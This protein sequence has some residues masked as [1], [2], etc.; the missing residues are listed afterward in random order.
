M[1]LCIVY[2]VRACVRACICVHIYIH[3]FLACITLV[4]VSFNMR[5]FMEIWFDVT[6]IFVVVVVIVARII[7]TLSIA[8]L[9][10]A[11]IIPAPQIWICINLYNLELLYCIFSYDPCVQCSNVTRF[12]GIRIFSVCFYL[13]SNESKQNREMIGKKKEHPK[14][15]VFRQNQLCVSVCTEL[16]LRIT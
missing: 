8:D 12:R 15:Y 2:D 10:K 6:I 1:L 13:F 11:E 4:I 14:S 9:S 7:E 5:H 16:F 3:R